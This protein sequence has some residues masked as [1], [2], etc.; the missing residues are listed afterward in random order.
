MLDAVNKGIITCIADGGMRELAKELNPNVV[1]DTC[2][3]HSFQRL[4][5]GTR[6][7]YLKLFDEAQEENLNTILKFCD[8]AK[9]DFEDPDADTISRL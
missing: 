2:N 7:D 9:K 8:K 5:L 6:G 1:N 3:W 4:G